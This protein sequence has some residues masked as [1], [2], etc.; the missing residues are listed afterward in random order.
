MLPCEK[1]T[2]TL[3]KLPLLALFFSATEAMASTSVA[4]AAA[5]PRTKI[6]LGEDGDFELARRWIDDSIKRSLHKIHTENDTHFLCKMLPVVC[7]R[8]ARWG[9]RGIS[10]MRCTSETCGASITMD[11][12]GKAVIS[13]A[14][15]APNWGL[16]PDDKLRENPVFVLNDGTQNLGVIW[17][18]VR[19]GE[20]TKPDS[21]VS[22][23]A[24]HAVYSV[25]LRKPFDA[26]AHSMLADHASEDAVV[27]DLPLGD[28]L[29]ATSLASG[30]YFEEMYGKALSSM[31]EDMIDMLRAA[32]VEA[33]QELDLPNPFA[34]VQAPTWYINKHFTALGKSWEGALSEVVASEGLSVS[35]GS[36]QVLGE[37]WTFSVSA[38]E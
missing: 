38:A 17:D 22:H 25:D 6:M 16:G 26:M 27:A 11:A 20:A 24:F 1:P 15:T 36:A 30:S 35:V 14:M 34:V 21:S 7:Q 29:Q 12:L 13:A 18:P 10:I 9:Y 37:R 33:G 8:A 19:E 3:F 5:A 2:H 31:C 23:E 4:P 28:N 32:K